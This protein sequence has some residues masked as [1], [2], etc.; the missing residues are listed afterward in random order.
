VTIALP[1]LSLHPERP[2]A[3]LEA[4]MF[5]LNQREDALLH[6]CEN[7]TLPWVWDIATPTSERRELRILS[8]SLTAI[9][10]GKPQPTYHDVDEVIEDLVPHHDLKSTQLQVFL[11]CSSSHVSNLLRA[12]CLAA[13]APRKAESGI[14]SATWVRRDSVVE[15]LRS[16]RF[17]G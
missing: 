10:T 3:P 8:E 17:T 15:F 5:I 1:G 12:G 14:H 7:G 16:R 4:A 2:L 11:T 6:S 13:A 9:A